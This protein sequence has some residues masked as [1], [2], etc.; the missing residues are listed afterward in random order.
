MQEVL[1][2]PGYEKLPLAEQ[3]FYEI[4]LDESNETEPL[5]FVVRQA[6]YI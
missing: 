5:G 2:K 4:S 6:H 3:E 1:A